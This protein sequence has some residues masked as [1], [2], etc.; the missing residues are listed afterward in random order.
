MGLSK[1]QKG[2]VETLTQVIEVEIEKL[3][4]KVVTAIYDVIN[5]VAGVALVASHGAV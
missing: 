1:W 4:K 2:F 5:N 3:Y